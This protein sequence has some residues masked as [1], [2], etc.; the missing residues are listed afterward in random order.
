VALI[1][2]GALLVALVISVLI[3][4]SAHAFLGADAA[5]WLPYLLIVASVAGYLAVLLQLREASARLFVVLL[6]ALGAVAAFVIA[7]GVLFGLGGGDPL[8]GPVFAF[9]LFTAPGVYIVAALS[10]LAA[11]AFAMGTPPHRDGSTRSIG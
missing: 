6:P 9:G 7:G 10:A 3:V 5:G 4:G 11:A 8:R 2:S 1:T